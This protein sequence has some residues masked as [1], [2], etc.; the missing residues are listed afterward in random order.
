MSKSVGEN[1]YSAL[2]KAVKTCYLISSNMVHR[3]NT[4]LAITPIVGP[5][6]RQRSRSVRLGLWVCSR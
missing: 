4:E 1:L 3:G 2:T 5:A 6:R